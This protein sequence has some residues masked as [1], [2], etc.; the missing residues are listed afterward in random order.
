MYGKE[1]FNALAADHPDS[2]LLRWL[3]ARKWDI[4]NAVEQLISTLKWRVESGVN[5]LVASGES[6]LS[7]EELLTGKT[8]YIGYDKEG[9]PVNYVSVKDHVK[10]EF[11]SSDTEKL[12]MFLMETGRKLLKYPNESVTVIFDMNGFS[13]RNMD[14]QHVRFLIHLL[15]NYYPESLGLAL[16]L[17][18]PWLF[19]SCWFIIKPWIDPVVQRKIHFIKN[20]NDLNKYLDP[21]ILPQSTNDNQTNCNYVPPTEQD[22][23]IMKTLRDDFYGKTKA[24]EYHRT[25]AND[26]IHITFQWAKSNNP[27]TFLEQRNKL[28][29]QLKDAYEQVIPYIST[30]THYHRIS[31]IQE[32]FFQQTFEKITSNNEEKLSYF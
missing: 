3:R 5:E 30:I 32:P 18:A 6:E 28:I 1:L 29:K 7:H 24:I 8:S 11:P 17:N 13:M 26:F 25:I 22:L 21:S 20:T 12:T 15:E 23:F 14:Y 2:V 16:V 19:N 10:G 31:L 9:R 27:N 4:P